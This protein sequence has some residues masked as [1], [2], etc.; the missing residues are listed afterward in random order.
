MLQHP[1]FPGAVTRLFLNG[2]KDAAEILLPGLICTS[3]VIT[4]I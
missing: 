1:N 2:I 4:T 3:S